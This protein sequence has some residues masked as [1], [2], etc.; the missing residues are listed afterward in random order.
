MVTSVKLVLLKK[1]NFL[2][3]IEVNITDSI[4]KKLDGHLADWKIGAIKYHYKA[5]K[6]V[7]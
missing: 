5:K 2:E 7:V 3:Q 4:S 6:K 1:D